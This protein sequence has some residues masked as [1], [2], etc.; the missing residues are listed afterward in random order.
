MEISECLWTSLH[1]IA[2]LESSWRLLNPVSECLWTSLHPIAVLESSWRFL[3]PATVAKCLQT[4][5]H[6][7]AILKSLWR[8]LHP[9]SVTKSEVRVSHA[10]S[11]C[12]PQFWCPCMD[13]PV[14]LKICF[15]E[16]W[17]TIKYQFKCPKGLHQNQTDT[18]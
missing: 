12:P 11:R 6:P 18:P 4:S 3:H 5:L 8:F 9:V 7:T 10:P 16:V 13:A 17:H 2:V 14:G 1:P 15:R